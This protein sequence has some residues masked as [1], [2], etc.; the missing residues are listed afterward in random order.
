[1]EEAQVAAENPDDKRTV[2]LVSQEGDNFE[3]PVGVATMSELVKTM[4]DGKPHQES[5]EKT[6]IP[7]PNVKNNVLSKVIEFCHHHREDPMMDIEK[8]LK[9]ANM[10][11]VVQEW[12]ANFV[13][14]EQELL[15]ELILAANY[16]DIKALLDLTCATV[17]SMIKG[18]T[19]EEIRK[20]FNICND[21]TPEE[22][23]QVREENK[24]CEEA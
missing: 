6:E 23:A 24:W 21:F 4:I 15:F 18:K 13:Q 8:P 3:V 12:Y 19:P 7:L 22:E 10:H 9:S 11:E 16:M 2:N 1:A 20:T 14:V 17:A 5:A